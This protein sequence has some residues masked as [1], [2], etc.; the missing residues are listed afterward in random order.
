MAFPP[1][2]IAADKAPGPP[3]DDNEHPDHHN[4]LATAI[5]DIVAHVADFG[6]GAG[7]NSNTTD[8]GAIVIGPYSDGSANA[9]G[10]ANGAGSEIGVDALGAVAF[11]HVRGGGRILSQYDG[12]FVGGSA[13][14]DGLIQA[15]LPPTG[16]I[17]GYGYDEEEN[18]G[19]IFGPA[20]PPVAGLVFGQADGAG[21]EISGNGDGVL[22]GGVARNGGTIAGGVA[23]SVVWGVSDGGSMYGGYGPDVV[24][25]AA[26]GMPSFV[27]G[28]FTNG[29]YTY[30]DQGG[31][32]FMGWADGPGSH[33][34]SDDFGAFVGGMAKSGG[35]LY[36]RGDGSFTFGDAV[37]GGKLSAKG[38]GSLAVGRVSY[39]LIESRGGGAMARGRVSG[40]ALIQTHQQGGFAG[41]LA[42]S[43]TFSLESPIDTQVQSRGNGSFAHGAAIQRGLIQA[44]ADGSAAFGFANAGNH[45][46]TVA[47]VGVGAYF[48]ND[49]TGVNCPGGFATGWAVSES[50][51]DDASVWA[52]NI[53]AFSS[54]YAKAA[55][56]D[57]SIMAT[58]VGSRSLG[59]AIDYAILASGD[60]AFAG[61][62]ATAANI[63]ASGHGAF[64]WGPG[65]NTHPDSLAV[66]EAIRL[67]STAPG[68]PRDG[69]IW[70]AGGFLY[71]RSSG[72]TG[73]ISLI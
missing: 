69:D 8:G 34:G 67:S 22:V 39:G 48:D 62:R 65:T 11:G 29:A 73:K 43:Y 71:G 12:F 60:G 45:P 63:T 54:G 31:S 72:T 13:V 41:G 44:G 27:W 66:G 2:P 7:L 25:R 55:T 16:P 23:G 38:E 10:Y 18:Y 56:A 70:V 64:Q 5:N 28:K 6:G 30:N 53:G 50:E 35:R 58:G 47:R 21:S 19:P 68:T 37:N 32:I 57:T 17:I 26:N 61:G 14:D 51:G 20:I 3:I 33:L 42:Q 46:D 1:D 49:W 4:E 15:S 52:N 36:G 9:F 59:F 24:N 40:R